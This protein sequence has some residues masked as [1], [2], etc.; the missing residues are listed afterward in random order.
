M[1]SKREEKEQLKELLKGQLSEKQRFLVE[2]QLRNIEAGERGEK[3][4]AYFVD[5]YFGKSKNWAVIHDLR[6]EHNGQVAQ[7]DHLVMNRSMN[8]H[9]LETKNF[10]Y[11]L[12]IT[13]EGEFLVYDGKKY[14]GIESPIEQN[15]RHIFLLSKAIDHYSIMPSRLGVVIPPRL[16]SYVLVSPTS[17]II[18]P[19]RSKLDTSH[20]IQS[21][22]AFTK[23]MK[24][25]DDVGAAAILKICSQE[26]LEA[27]AKS[28]AKLHR[29]AKVDF[30]ARFGIRDQIK[31]TSQPEKTTP[32]GPSIVCEAC[33]SKVSEKVVQYCIDRKHLYKGR[34]LCY[35][36]QRSAPA[37]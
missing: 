18:R 21:D 25:A 13:P 2:K 8:I 1:D 11:G 31:P 32:E 24:D 23:I 15:E 29:P 14:F 16:V 19:S 5:F 37:L 17:K 9:V 20:V 7:I 28:L 22:Q 26:T 6:I 36:C 34:I 27:T 12:K 3:D 10:H 30:K 33:S 4:S 35:N